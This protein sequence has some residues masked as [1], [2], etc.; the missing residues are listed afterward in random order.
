MP[1]PAAI[2]LAGGASRRM[3]RAKQAL[4][5][6]GA[7]LL[8]RSI[9]AARAA[10]CT[11]VVVVA[12]A[13]RA[14]DW[15]EPAPDLILALE[16]PPGGGPVAGIIAGTLALAGL[17]DA[18][19]VLLLACDLPRAP[20]LAAQLVDHLAEHGAAHSVVPVDDEGWAQNLCSVHPLAELRSRAALHGQGRDL[21]VRAFF[22]GLEARGPQLTSELLADVDT[23]EQ[24]RG[25][26]V[27]LG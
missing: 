21:S 24:A 19:P 17:D 23:P 22:S 20:E 12:P 1:S 27:D 2:I 9:D 6:D 5:L 13:D 26:G 10:G 4:L 3:G 16:D 15:F 18:T 7:S 14:G 11:Q 8:Q 25:A